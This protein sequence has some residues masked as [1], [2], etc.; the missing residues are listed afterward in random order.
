MLTQAWIKN[1]SYWKQIQ[2]LL[3]Q[4]NYC[5][6]KSTSKNEWHFENFEN[7]INRMP[8]RMNGGYEMTWKLSAFIKRKFYCFEDFIKPLVFYCVSKNINRRK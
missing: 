2:Q 7:F 3:E 4:K 6:E 8:N 1:L 5:N